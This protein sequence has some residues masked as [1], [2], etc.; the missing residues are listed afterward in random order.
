MGLPPPPSQCLGVPWVLPSAPL[1]QQ[2]RD[3]KWPREMS[4][5]RLKA[6]RGGCTRKC[7]VQALA[8]RRAVLGSSQGKRWPRLPSEASA[9]TSTPV[10]TGTRIRGRETWK[11]AVR[12]PLGTRLSPRR[13][14]PNQHVLGNQ[15]E[16]TP[17]SAVASWSVRTERGESGPE[18]EKRASGEVAVVSALGPLATS[19][20]LRSRMLWELRKALWC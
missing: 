7:R 13:T 5:P 17:G 3:R 16:R 12:L 2:I 20:P 18:R 1:S 8:N 10:P 4:W 15:W 6:G 14:Y 11:A 9:L 19:D